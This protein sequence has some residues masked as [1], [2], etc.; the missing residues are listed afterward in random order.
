[1]SAKAGA[2]SKGSRGGARKGAGRP[3]DVDLQRLVV[4]LAEAFGYQGDARVNPD[5]I[6]NGKVERGQPW[7]RE[8]ERGVRPKSIR[9]AAR[10][11]ARRHLADRALGPRARVRLENALAESIRSGYLRARKE[12]RGDEAWREIEVQPAGGMESVIAVF[13]DSMP[14]DD[15]DE[16]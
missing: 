2:N 6:V 11:V 13:D 3:I 8:T 5:R 4:E 10:M 7:S 12:G 16:S 9:D 15:D 14:D 1:M